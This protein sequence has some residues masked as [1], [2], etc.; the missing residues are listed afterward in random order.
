VGI[1]AK[2]AGATTTKTVAEQSAKSKD[3]SS[4]LPQSQASIPSLGRVTVHTDLFTAEIDEQGGD[5][6]KLSFHHHHTRDGKPYV[7]LSDE[8]NKIMVIQSGFTGDATIP[9]HK[10]RFM[11][12]Q[13]NYNLDGQKTISV[14]LEAEN[15]DWKAQKIYSFKQGSYEIMLRQTIV[16]KTSLAKA[17]KGYVQILRDEHPA[18]DASRFI[19]SFTG[20]A[21]YIPN[22]GFEKV[23]FKKFKDT[24]TIEAPSGWVSMLQH[25]FVTA[26]IPNTTFQIYG[27]TVDS[28]LYA[29]GAL[30][31]LG[32]I[33]PT[34]EKP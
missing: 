8:A 30:V 2:R 1:L 27:R 14:T 16:N 12:Q 4:P 18:P 33:A 23:P 25:Y 19:H 22:G 10:T 29:M 11:A 28:E 5:L 24:I 9:N 31:P 20:G 15:N 3:S 34:A 32:D 13:K 7:L 21:Y 17:I 26:L 6:R